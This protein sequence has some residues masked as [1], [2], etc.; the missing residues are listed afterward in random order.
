VWHWTQS[1]VRPS[2]TGA[3]GVDAVDQRVE[4]ELE[5]VDA[6]FLVDHGVAVEAGGDA[7][8]VAGAGE[9]VPGELLEGEAVEG[10]VVVVGADHPVA[11]RPHR[12]RTV[13]LVPVRVGVAGEVEPA[14]GPALPVVGR[15]EQPVDVL[16]IGVRRGVAQEGVGLLG[17][18][19]QA[20][21]IERDAA[22]EDGAVG[23]GAAERVRRPRA[24]RGGRRRRE[25][26]SRRGSSREAAPRRAAP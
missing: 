12:A 19:R 16:L 20:G 25:C 6:A 3:V 13:L 5:R 1:S 26:G 9:H 2:Q 4:A 17:R 10:Q 23:F 22:G 15:G 7:G 21:E 14:T 8:R 11:V 18:R 24:S